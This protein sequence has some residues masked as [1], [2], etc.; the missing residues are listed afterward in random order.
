MASEPDKHA[1]QHVPPAFY[2]ARVIDL[3]RRMVLLRRFEEKLTGMCDRGASARRGLSHAG[4]EAVAVGAISALSNRDYLVSTYRQHGHYLARGG[5]PKIVAADLL[6]RAAGVADGRGHG[7][8]LFDRDLRFVGGY[9]EPRAGLPV[10]VGLALACQNEDQPNAVCC[11]FGDSALADEAFRESL[12]FAAAWNLPLVFVCENNFYG[13]G[14]MFDG[15]ECQEEL[16][17]FA[18]SCKIPAVRVDG[19]ELLEVCRATSDA[20]ARAR[21]GRGPSLVDAVTY[22]L[23]GEYESGRYK[24]ASLHHPRFWL[25][26]DPI[27]IARTALLEEAKVAVESLDAIDGVLEREVDR[28]IASAAQGLRPPQHVRRAGDRA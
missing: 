12:N 14:T 4:E 13:M 11:M 8:H 23:R 10:A 21:S 6:G 16:Y 9:S 17:R 22:R 24:N 1:A 19:T 2:D 28:A 18:E 20:A 27:R 3:Y 26:R 7:T 5:N 25:D 15:P